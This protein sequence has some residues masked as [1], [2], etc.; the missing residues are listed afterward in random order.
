MPQTYEQQR[1]RRQPPGVGLA[2][3]RRSHGITLQTVVDRISDATGRRYTV[4]AISA[5]ELG[6]RGAS[7][8][9]LDDIASVFGLEAADFVTTPHRETA[10]VA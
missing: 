10:D 9:M 2:A 3:L 1:P 4:G 8:Q 5:I 6:H 7:A